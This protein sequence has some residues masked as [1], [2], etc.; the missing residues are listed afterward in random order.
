MT[1]L[2]SKF[3]RMRFAVIIVLALIAASV[4]AFFTVGALQGNEPSTIVSQQPVGPNGEL[5]PVYEPNCPS[6][7]DKPSD[8]GPFR[9]VPFCAAFDLPTPLPPEPT[10]P[11]LATPVDFEDLAVLRSSP[12]YVE[13]DPSLVPKGY[14]YSPPT[15]QY[16]DPKTGE[17]TMI[18]WSFRGPLVAVTTVD[19]GPRQI[20]TLIK[21]PP[22]DGWSTVET[23][24]LGGHPA[25]FERNKPG[26]ASG[27]QCVYFAEDDIF[28]FVCG[29][30]ED[31]NDLVKLAEY[32]SDHSTLISKTP[33]PISNTGVAG[34]ATKVG[35]ADKSPQVS[36]END[37][38]Q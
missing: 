8:Y 9:L 19:R 35:S 31:F 14:A 24:E 2:R 6:N 25:I 21:V 22:S 16:R 38:P 29:Y 4:A 3:G 33:G 37:G 1:A 15:G 12:V 7:P 11:I 5:E 13:I 34:M 30:V 18:S 23:G 27:E 17:I 32:V 26:V 28:T 20:P 10:S 36:P